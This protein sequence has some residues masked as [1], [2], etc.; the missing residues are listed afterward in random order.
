LTRRVVAV[1]ADKWTDQ[2]LLKVI[3]DGARLLNIEFP[4]HF[5]N[6]LL[7]ESYDSVYI[8]QEVCAAACINEKVRETQKQLYTIG[9]NLVVSELVKSVVAQQSG[10]YMSF[11][12]QFAEG[13][14]DTRLE[15][16]KWLL[17]PI[18]TTDLKELQEGIGYARIR[19]IL[20]AS[21]PL[22][23]DLNPGNLT[24]ALQSAAS[25]QVKKDI[26]PIIL[27]YDQTNRRLNVVDRGFFI[28]LANQH[29]EELLEEAGFELSR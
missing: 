22:R 28:W 2:E 7:H 25:L 29:R 13:F 4:S 21:H 8:V 11:I 23:K 20:Q 26:K 10:R 5:K 14:Q 9:N 3:D 17:Y 24:Q 1:D 27:D 6:E 12:T 19:E 15:M 16:H 18:L